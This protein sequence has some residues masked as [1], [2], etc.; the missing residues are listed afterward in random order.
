MELP[1]RV[2]RARG[3]RGSRRCARRRSDRGR[4]PP[5][6]GSSAAADRGCGPCGPRRRD[7]R[8]ER[9]TR[10]DGPAARAFRRA[11]DRLRSAPQPAGAR[12]SGEI[13]S[14]MRWTGCSKGALGM[15]SPGD[16]RSCGSLYCRAVGTPLGSRPSGRHFASGAAT[17]LCR[18]WPFGRGRHRRSSASLRRP[19][20]AYIDWHGRC[21]FACHLD[22]RSRG[23]FHAAT[24]RP[25][26][27][28]RRESPPVPR[29]LTE[30]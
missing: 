9:R 7:G 3:R 16:A 8:R 27:R 18:V 20:L 17:T 11:G 13:R 29:S 23:G 28:A 30:H 26:H 4:R 24:A 1:A 2:L 5:S 15:R 21:F 14:R 25:S 6:P 12:R 19:E 22:C 10:R